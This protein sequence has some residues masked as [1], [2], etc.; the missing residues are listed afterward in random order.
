MVAY[1]RWSKIEMNKEVNAN[2]L[3]FF[4]LA[5]YFLKR[6]FNIQFMYVISKNN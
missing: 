5:I 6:N 2:T 4:I 1:S 3:A